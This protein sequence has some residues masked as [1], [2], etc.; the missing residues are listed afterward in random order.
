MQVGHRHV[1]AS[2]IHGFTLVE[3]VTVIILIGILSITVVSRFTGT[4]GYEAVNYRA[5]LISALR[6]EQQRAM[7]Q[8]NSTNCH[9]LVI[10]STRYG[11][12]DSSNCTIT[13]FPAQ[14]SVDTDSTGGIVDSRYHVTFNVNGATSSQRIA[15]DDMGRP[16]ANCAGGCL[17]NVVEPGQTATIKIE[18]EGYIHAL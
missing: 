18:S 14:W 1:Y 4:A 10:E 3:L 9:Q 16:Q 13:N 2:S 17:I 8:T 11:T 5:R 7:Q 6:L 12:P 15:F